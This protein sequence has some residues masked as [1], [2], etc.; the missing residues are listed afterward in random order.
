[1]ENQE[2]LPTTYD[3]EEVYSYLMRT[4]LSEVDIKEAEYVSY[5]LPYATPG[6]KRNLES[7]CSYLLTRNNLIISIRYT[8]K[9][10]GK[11]DILLT[12]GRPSSA[13]RIRTK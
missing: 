9:G 8:I 6:E 1:M 12:I 10:E 11:G 13:R 5:V 3:I 7:A 2:T 4:F